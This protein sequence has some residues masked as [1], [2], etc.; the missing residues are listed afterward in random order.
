MAR[1]K[2]S[3][4]ESL[5]KLEKLIEKLESNDLALDEALDYFEQGV[6]LLRACDAHLKSAEG[7]L[8]ELLTGE[9]GEFIEKALGI[10]LASVVGGEDFDE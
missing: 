8:K 5:T 4:E 3:F 1:K 10:S 7:T 6:K 9:D 2:E